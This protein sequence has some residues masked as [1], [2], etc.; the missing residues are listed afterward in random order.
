MGWLDLTHL[1]RHGIE[2][3]VSAPS[4]ERTV[5]FSAAGSRFEGML[6]DDGQS[7]SGRWYNENGVGITPV[8]GTPAV[9]SAPTGYLRLNSIR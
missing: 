2:Q 1:Y 7:I 3:V 6:A 5:V 4:T 9:L 8:D